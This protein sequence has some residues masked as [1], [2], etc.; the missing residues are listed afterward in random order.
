MTPISITHY[1][2][3]SALGH[4]KAATLA[5]LQADRSGLRPNDFAD[6]PLETYIGRVY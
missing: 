3:T 5:A 1:T 6:A 4:G 2:L